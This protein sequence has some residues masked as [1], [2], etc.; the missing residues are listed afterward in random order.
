MTSSPLILAIGDSL[1]AGYGLATADGFA[2]Q[3]ERRLRGRYSEASVRPAARSGDTSADAL[4]R[5]P[6][7]L[8]SLRARPDLAI[9]QVGPNDMLRRIAPA[10]TRANLD[11]ILVEL[12]RCGV[13]V[14]LTTVAPP[15]FL[16]GQA[17]DYLGIHTEVAARHGAE[18]WPFVPPGVLGHPQ[19]VLGDRVHP[20]A[21]AIARVTDAMLPVVERMLGDA[22]GSA[23]PRADA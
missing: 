5:L 11:A 9:V 1:V 19:M 22:H 2:A 3:L 6:T 15:P 17:R 4:R 7:I 8:S 13:P 10:T 14:L 18:T 20:N 16:Q 12:G 23:P 21:A